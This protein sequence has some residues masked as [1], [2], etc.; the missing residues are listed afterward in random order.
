MKCG[1]ANA[2]S[3]VQLTERLID[4]G[5]QGIEVV[6]PGGDDAV[7]RIEK[8]SGTAIPEYRHGDRSYWRIA[9]EGNGIAAFIAILDDHV[10]L[11]D[12]LGDGSHVRGCLRAPGEKPRRDTV[13]G[14]LGAELVVD[15]AQFDRV[16][17]DLSQP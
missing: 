6:G 10:A 13:L 16:V 7:E 3:G 1:D 17:H 15:P 8:G 5:E 14:E 9:D 2:K 4:L 11:Q 12:R